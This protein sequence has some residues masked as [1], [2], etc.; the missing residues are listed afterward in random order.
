MSRLKKPALCTSVL[1]LMG[2]N[3]RRFMPSATKAA[4]CYGRPPRE[5]H[6]L[7]HIAR[8]SPAESKIAAPSAF[9]AIHI[10]RP[11]CPCLYKEGD[12][13]AAGGSFLAW[14]DAWPGDEHRICDPTKLT[15]IWN[16]KGLAP[17]HS[18]V[19]ASHKP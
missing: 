12:S 6:V 18:K 5:T 15:S 8:D 7:F 9:V 10:V 1:R 13:A 11:C 17:G 2:V 16:G 19:R 3:L 14:P 4:D